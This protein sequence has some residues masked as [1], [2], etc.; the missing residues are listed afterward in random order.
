MVG[1]IQTARGAFATSCSPCAKWEPPRARCS[2]RRPPTCGG[3]TSR[4][5]ER[6]IIRSSTRRLGGFSGTARR[7][8][9]VVRNQ[10]DALAPLAA[11]A[12]VL[13]ADYYVPHI[14]HAPMEPP[15]AAASVAD[16]RCE[17]WAC[18]QNPQGARDEIAKALGIPANRV[19][20]NVTLLGG[21][22]GRKSKPDY[23]VEAALLSRA[24]GAPVKVTWTR[25]DEI[26]HD[27][28]HTVT[29]QH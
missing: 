13:K 18:T 11:P 10:G 16:G 4:R 2:R 7:P 25:E 8:G 22:F 28:Y 19:K 24:A 15:A 1:R 12:R 17:A 20:V 26:Q 27:Y 3:W 5:S 29:A 23:V 9:K 21:G 14:A 6:A